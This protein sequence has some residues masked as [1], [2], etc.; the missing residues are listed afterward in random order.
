MK[1]GVE[2]AISRLCWFVVIAVAIA[3]AIS[4]ALGSIVN[5][6]ESGVNDPVVIRDELRANQH[7]LS[8]M[9]M[10]PTPC[11]ELSVRTESLSKTNFAILLKTWHEPSVNCGDEA[12]PRTFETVLFA[13]A[14]GVTFTATLDDKEFPI[15]VIP[16]VIRA[17]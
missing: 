12:T 7:S 8:G 5:A 10:V 9:V 4:L 11:D 2:G 13:P 17:H 15:A 3:Y 16:I 6:Q 14:A 1:E